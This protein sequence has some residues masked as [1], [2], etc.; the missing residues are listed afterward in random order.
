MTSL[1]DVIFLLLLFFMLTS[2]FTKF[3]EVE[4][5]IAGGSTSGTPDTR[6]LFVQLESEK[7]TLNGI[8]V[9]LATLP[10][11]LGRQRPENETLALIISLGG[12]ITAQRLTDFLVALR[13]VPGVQAA[14]LGAT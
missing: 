14:F 9:P 1:I 7:I 13:R 10:D 11:A 4:L 5:A 6:P 2:T 12:A 3:S 8:V